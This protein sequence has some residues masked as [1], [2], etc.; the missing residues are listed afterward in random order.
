MLLST[1]I[2]SQIWKVE[3]LSRHILAYSRIQLT[4]ILQVILDY[5]L[6]TNDIDFPLNKQ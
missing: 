5:A 6:I 2:F 1:E 3:P 4:N